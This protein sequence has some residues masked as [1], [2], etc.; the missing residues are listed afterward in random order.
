MLV[1]VCACERES[2]KVL[3]SD[4]QQRLLVFHT[5]LIDTGLVLIRLSLACTQYHTPLTQPHQAIY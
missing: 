4:V 3:Q 1:C 2:A 5:R